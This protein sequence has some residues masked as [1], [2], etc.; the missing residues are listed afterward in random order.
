[1]SQLWSW[2]RRH[3]VVT[4]LIVLF[5]AVGLSDSSTIIGSLVVILILLG[6][7]WIVERRKAGQ[8]QRDR[9]GRLAAQQRPKSARQGRSSN[10][11]MPSG[12]DRRALDAHQ[13]MLD[14]QAAELAQREQ[15]LGE[16][17]DDALRRREQELAAREADIRRRETGPFSTPQQATQM[18]PQQMSPQQ[19]AAKTDSEQLSPTGQSAF[20]ETA[21]RS[22]PVAQRRE[23][24]LITIN[25]LL[26]MTPTEFEEFCVKA[27]QGIGYA[28]VRRVGGAGDLTA[29]IFG[30]DN[31]GRSTVVQCKRYKPGTK[32]GSPALQMF[33]GMKS[34]HHEA[35]R[36][37]YMTTADYSVPAVRLAKQHDIVLIDGDDMVKIAGLVMM[38][39]STPQ[40][41]AGIAR[42]CA[43]C[44]AE[45]TTDAR[46]CT[47]CGAARAA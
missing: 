12:T 45:F 19:M 32:V 44:G 31:M 8:R 30:I 28:E 6:V 9:D 13:Q 23:S 22:I 35:E 33:I 4:I 46:F 36:G 11:Q 40:V 15:V 24:S 38:P 37:I 43:S 5:G 2:V 29:D 14:R 27:L 41:A 7:A 20:V 47:S 18:S 17:Q 25:H 39:K 26:A 3:P 1:M 10:K 34:V 42:Y 16:Q 21:H